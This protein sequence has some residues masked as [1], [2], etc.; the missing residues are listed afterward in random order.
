MTGHT[1]L[2]I[3]DEKDI[4][5]LLGKVLTAKNYVVA[6][7]NNLEDGLIKL[8]EMKPSVLFLD[9]RLPD[10]S[11]LDAVSEIRRKNPQMKIVMMSAY[12][13][14]NERKQG[15]ELGAD[16]FIGKPLNSHLINNI[17]QSIHSTSAKP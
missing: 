2:I 15:I 11:G 14:A 3:D 12:D 7:A 10:G 6:I 4:C 16:L 5:F 9:I 13:G 8:N 17:L 1:V